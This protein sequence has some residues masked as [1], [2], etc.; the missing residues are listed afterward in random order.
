MYQEIEIA[1]DKTINNYCRILNA[2]Y[3]AHNNTG[4]TE[5]NLTHNFVKSLESTLGNNAIA[6]LEAFPYTQLK[7][8]ESLS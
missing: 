7:V 6:W 2:Y 5:R 3:P 8:H 4:F 1:F